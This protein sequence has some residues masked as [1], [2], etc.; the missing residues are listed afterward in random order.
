MKSLL[1]ILYFLVILVTIVLLVGLFLPKEGQIES[2]ISIRATPEIVFEQINILKNWEKWSPWFTAD[3]TMVPIYNEIP[4]GVGA[5]YSW[6][7]LHSGNGKLSITNSEPFR[8]LET[9]IDFG[10]NGKSGTRFALTEEQEETRLT[11]TFENKE[12]GYFERYFMILFKKNMLTSINKGLQDIKKISQEIKLD[13]ISDVS[14]VDIAAQPALC[15]IDS[16]SADKV[17]E[18]MSELYKKLSAYLEVRKMQPVGPAFTIFY[19][20]DTE[21]IVR[22]ACCL[23]ISART[24]GW[25]EYSYIELPGG[26]AA[27]LTHWGILGTSKPYKALENY[28]NDN[29]LAMGDMIWEISKRDPSTEADTSK[30]EVQIYSPIKQQVNENSLPL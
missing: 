30:W 7:S 23:P 19:K 1:K 13:R 3:T 27:T 2:S 22:F 6:E 29:N 14:I 15:I 11:W 12:L 10:I 9:L 5:S 21:D 26:K 25:K 8:A 16:T 17:R 28:M 20:R 24:W 18:K 4:S